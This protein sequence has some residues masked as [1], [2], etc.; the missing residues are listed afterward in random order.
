MSINSPQ[1]HLQ[2][3]V[4]ARCQNRCQHCYMY[5]E[6]TYESEIKNELSFEDCTRIID[7]FA[8]TLQ[9]LSA[10]GSIS[11]TGG[12]P[13]LREDIFDIMKYAGDREINI[14]IMGNPDF[15]DSKMALKLRQYRVSS[16]QMSLDGLEE[17]HDMLRS[18]GNF[19]SVIRASK[20]LQEAG[21]WVNIMNTLSRHNASDL[22][23]LMRVVGEEGVSSFSF[24]RLAAVGSGTQYRDD[25][26]KPFEYRELLLQYF[27]EA[28]LLRKKGIRTD[29]RKKDHLWIP[30]F[31]E[32]GW[33]QGI[34][35]TRDSMFYGGCA[36]GGFGLIVLA[37][38]TAMACRRFPSIIGKMPE[39]S[40]TEIFFQ[41]KELNRM[42]DIS[43]FEKCSRCELGRF[44]RG[45]PAAA[46]GANRSCFSPDP[47]CWK[48][49]KT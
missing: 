13:L 41:S 32:E 17:L 47:Q 7:D 48:E 8:G 1:L 22:I 2:W 43:N 30:L 45:C 31:L 44:C 36:A 28:M 35:R 29:Y 21:I 14:G 46:Y 24:A 42:R 16:Y 4:T 19:S 5:D 37:D 39:Q 9:R 18:K 38:G 15:I 11:F 12:D 34:P 6:E 20:I 3:H 10:R 25:L 33:L 49:I 27:K 23:A 26:L 40:F